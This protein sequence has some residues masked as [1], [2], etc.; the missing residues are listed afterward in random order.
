MVEKPKVN[1]V[2]A[3]CPQVTNHYGCYMHIYFTKFNY[4]KLLRKVQSLPSYMW[5]ISVMKFISPSPDLSFPKFL[6]YNSFRIKIPLL[7][8]LHSNFC[9][10]FN[11]T[12][13][14]P[15]RGIHYESP[16]V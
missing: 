2:H 5:R 4:L 10:I 15:S 8:F 12:Q 1:E 7:L 11:S 14:N 16:H 3:P 13:R 9:L 6:I